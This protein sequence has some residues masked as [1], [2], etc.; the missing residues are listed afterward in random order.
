MP[1]IVRNGLGT[2][3]SRPEEANLLIL[4]VLRGGIEPPTH[5]FSGSGRWITLVAVVIDSVRVL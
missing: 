2:E 1:G 5:G 3:K 4:L